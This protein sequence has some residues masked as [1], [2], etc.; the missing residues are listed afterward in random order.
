M[1]RT[2]SD[3]S[4]Q[5]ERDRILTDAVLKA[6]DIIKLSQADLGD[7]IGES[8]ST[9]SRSAQGKRVIAENSKQGELAVIF[10]R[11]FR[12]LDAIVGG[13]EEAIRHWFR[14]EN[15]HLGGVPAT[16]VKR[17]EGL[18]NVCIYLDAMRGKV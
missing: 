2:Q 10:L 14:T 3:R 12:S 16:L 7:I 9:I 11:I 13:K 8:E 17:V 5:H 4:S 18:T 15:R 1:P 6:A